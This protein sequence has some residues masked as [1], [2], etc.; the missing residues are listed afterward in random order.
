M[1]DY[2]S[3]EQVK[4]SFVLTAQYEL[5]MQAEIDELRA[6]GLDDANAILKLIA[7]VNYMVGIAEKGE[8]QKASLDE[9][10][11]QFVLGYVKKLEAR[12]AELEAEHKSHG[13]TAEE[14]RVLSVDRYQEN[15]TL[16]ARVAE[17]EGKHAALQILVD[18][19][20]AREEGLVTQAI[21]AIAVRTK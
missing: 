15:L 7:T 18:L 19:A 10:P 11:E 6:R 20:E 12:V 3:A 17:L 16:S 9:L 8:G 1:L 21:Q 13:R 5:E 4:E 2:Y 14:W